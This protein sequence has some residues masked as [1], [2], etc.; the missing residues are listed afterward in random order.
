LEIHPDKSKIISLS[1]GADFVGFKLFYG[2]KSVRKRNV[3]SFKRKLKGLKTVYSM[4]NL[5]MEKFLEITDG[6]FSYMN[7]GDS[8]NL[9]IK[10][11]KEIKEILIGTGE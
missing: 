5:S 10:L 2:F 1:N 6:W 7:I 8:Y 9:R 4:G 11:F 3:R